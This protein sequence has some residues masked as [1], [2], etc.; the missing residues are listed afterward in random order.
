MKKV[1]IV[2]DDILKQ[3][4]MT[5]YELSKRTNIKFQTI[6]NYYKNKVI[7][8]DSDILLKICISLSCDIADIIKI[9]DIEE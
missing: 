3:Q 9:V 4:N 2:L 8:Y 7:R 5:R 6:D 1:R